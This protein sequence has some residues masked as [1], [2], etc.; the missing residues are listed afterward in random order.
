VILH[1]TNEFDL[2]KK[3]GSSKIEMVKGQDLMILSASFLLAL[4]NTVNLSILK[5]GE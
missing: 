5:I 2:H 4:L 3:I 1:Y